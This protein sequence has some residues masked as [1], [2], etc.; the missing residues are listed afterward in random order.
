MSMGEDK[1]S[2]DLFDKTGANEDE[3]FYNVI[4]NKVFNMFSPF[5]IDRNVDF[6][7]KDVLGG[8]V[9]KY[10][11]GGAAYFKIQR[12]MPSDEELKEIFEIGK[13]LKENFGE[14]VT[15][16]ILCTP[17]IEI[18][19]I[20]LSVF[21]DMAVDFLSIR[22]NEG[23]SILDSLMSKLKNNEEFTVE[24]HINRIIVPFMGRNDEVEFQLKYA[25]FTNLFNEMGVKQPAVSDLNKS[26]II[27]NRWFSDDFNFIF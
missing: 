25:E 16:S 19:N 27:Y 21:E 23:D 13:F 17:D 6:P 18:R 20:D 11:G 1:M 7:K 2:N 9:L 26:R 3:F 8:V 12:E 24:D 22:K 10:V 5:E 14:Y 15:L 4:M